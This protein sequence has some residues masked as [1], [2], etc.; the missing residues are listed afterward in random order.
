M[1]QEV[2]STR[3]A[4]VEQAVHDLCSKLKRGAD[5]YQ[6]VIFMAAISYDFGE[7]SRAIKDRFPN[8]E[9]IGTSTAGEISPAGFAEG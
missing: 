5:S 8:S 7:L 3:Q 9:V 4:S 2:V 1:E 6:A